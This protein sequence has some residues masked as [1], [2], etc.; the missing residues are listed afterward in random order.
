ML[1]LRSNQIEQIGRAH[2]V[3]QAIR[4][5]REN[6]RDFA[7]LDPAVTRLFVEDSVDEATGS[8]GLVEGLSVMTFVL[9]AWFLGPE[10]IKDFPEAD[11][12]L[13][14]P[15]AGEEDRMAHLYRWAWKRL[16]ETP[17]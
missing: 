11:V 13:R 16:G 17:S 12:I 14:N 9:V 4:H 3:E 15:K 1:K 10:F 6:H 8:Y 5:M 2:F 7:A